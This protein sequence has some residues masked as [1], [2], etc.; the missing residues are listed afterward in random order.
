MLQ[1]PGEGVYFDGG[2]QREQIGPTAPSKKKKRR[3]K[4][5]GLWEN[6]KIGRTTHGSCQVCRAK[7][8]LKCATILMMGTAEKKSDICREYF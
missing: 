6:T 4:N 2:C 7:K 1:S 8:K 3:R 5:A